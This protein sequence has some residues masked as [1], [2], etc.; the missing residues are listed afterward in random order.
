ME[1]I[2]SFSKEVVCLFD[3]E[4]R[5]MDY[6]TVYYVANELSSELNEYVKVHADEIADRINR[7]TDNWLTCRIVYL[8]EDNPLFAP[9]ERNDT[10]FRLDTMVYS[11]LLPAEDAEE[12]GQP[13]LAAQ[14]QVST[15]DWLEKAVT[16]YF[17]TLQKMLDESLDDGKWDASH[18]H[19]R[20]LYAPPEPYDEPNV[21]RSTR[22][23]TTSG[24]PI[25]AAAL[26]EGKG[27][28]YTILRH[29]DVSDTSD[30]DFVSPSS[31]S[32]DQDSKLTEEIVTF[33]DESGVV[34]RVYLSR[35]EIKS[36][37]Y[38]VVL[39]DY[40]QEFRFTAQVKALYVL[41]LN[42]P[43]GIRMKE[44]GDYRDEYK[45]L[46]FCLTNRS[47]TDKLKKSVDKLLDVCSPNALNVKKSQC[48]RA[49]ERILSDPKQNRY[50][51]I[52]VNRGGPHTVLLPRSLVTMPVELQW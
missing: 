39:P 4:Y 34:H 32:D 30:L 24:L 3:D 44:I 27:E 47:D 22:V 52:Q 51:T 8:E 46:Y 18:L 21:R 2:Q 11:A 25:K 36:G 41:F 29:L 17:E 49:V 45:R 12:D 13:F 40:N 35:L 23:E 43:E 15:T 7:N 28:E 31:I 6:G 16:E 26:E 37:A 42:H 20:I 1:S 38:D 10:L 48:N 50:Y 14:L 19:K 9:C 33:T 5:D